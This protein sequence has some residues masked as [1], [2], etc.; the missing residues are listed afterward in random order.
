M[1]AGLQLRRISTVVA[2]V[3]SAIGL[4]ECGARKT[5]DLQGAITPPPDEFAV[6]AEATLAYEQV[7]DSTRAAWLFIGNPI[8]SHT[9]DSHDEG[10]LAEAEVL[11]QHG[12]ITDEEFAK[13]IAPH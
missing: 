6:R 8:P 3:A 9:W 12:A 10:C 13:R 11:H 5:P 2:T 7:R 1:N 4:A